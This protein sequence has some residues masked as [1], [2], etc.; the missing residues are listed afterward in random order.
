MRSVLYF[1][2]ALVCL[3]MKVSYAEPPSCPPTAVQQ[4]DQALMNEAAKKAKDHG[5]LWKVAK[6]GH[7]SYLYGTIH[8]ATFEAMFPGPSIKKALMQADT[9]ALELDST[10]PSIMERLMKS[11]STI[12][13]YDI[14]ERLVNQIKEVAK[15]QCFP[16]KNIATMM[17][18]MQVMTLSLLDSRQDGLYVDYGIDMVLAGFGH[19]LKKNIVSLE[20][21]EMQMEMLRM[22]SQAETIK[23]VEQNLSQFNTGEARVLTQ[24]MFQSWESANYEDFE[25]YKDWCQCVDTEADKQFMER[26]LDQRN[27]KMVEKVDQLHASGESVFVAVGSLHMFGEKSL[28]SLM[29]QRGYEVEVVRF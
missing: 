26:I 25:H 9:I 16:Y 21:P 28:P 1:L 29:R 7:V 3:N 5:F 4:P 23:L 6:D 18:E 14:P 15:A 13:S 2:A 19:A 20:T 24:R 12:K 17:P 27:I 22:R 8:L 10:D 11:V